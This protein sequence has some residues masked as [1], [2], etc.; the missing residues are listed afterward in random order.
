MQL[1]YNEQK[2]KKKSYPL[3]NFNSCSKNRYT[4]TFFIQIKVT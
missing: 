4:K 3:K 1:I 2:R